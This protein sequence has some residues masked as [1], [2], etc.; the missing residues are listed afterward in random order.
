[1]LQKYCAILYLVNKDGI[2]DIYSLVVSGWFF[3]FSSIP[4]VLVLYLLMHVLIEEIN[5]EDVDLEDFVRFIFKG[6]Y[7]E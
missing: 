5:G 4:F 6:D 7:N 3:F 2:M 1:M